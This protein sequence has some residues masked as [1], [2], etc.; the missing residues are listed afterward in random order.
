MAFIQFPNPTP[1]FPALPSQAWSVHKQPLFKTNTNV[2]ISGREY[3]IARQVIPR[4]EF[5]LSYGG[6]AWLRDQTQNNPIYGPLAGFRELEQI[7]GLFLAC[8]GSYGEFYY[9]DPDDNSRLDQ[10]TYPGPG[11][12]ITTFLCLF[13]WGTG[14]FTPAAFY[15]VSGIQIL[16]AVY[17]NGV[18]QSP[19][20]YSLDSTRTQIVFTSAPSSGVDITADFHFYFRCRFLADVEE[21]S[22]WA[23]N[24]WELKELKFQSVKP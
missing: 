23:K 21:F 1:I 2:A 11:A 9:I 14:P 3:Q 15:P 5:T 13:N 8:L 19:S 12:G 16:D 18:A 22:Q 24:L 17:I 10:N 4:W 6:E 20:T 7:A